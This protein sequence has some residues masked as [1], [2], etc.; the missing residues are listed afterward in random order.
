[1]MR[2]EIMASRGDHH[3]IMASL[4][5]VC[6]S[7]RKDV[8]GGGAQI[9]S[10]CRFLLPSCIESEASEGK[11]IAYTITSLKL[12]LI[13]ITNHYCSLESTN[14]LCISM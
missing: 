3:G 8:G 2:G 4:L 7:I 5:C 11:V 14:K 10:R 1:M 13:F 9:A 12:L 6:V